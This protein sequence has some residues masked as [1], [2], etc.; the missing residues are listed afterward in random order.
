MGKLKTSANFYRRGVL[1]TNTSFGTNVQGNYS[2]IQP[3][4]KFVATKNF[5]NNTFNAI[6]FNRR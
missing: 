2:I 5:F 3:Y 4:S 6:R 1:N